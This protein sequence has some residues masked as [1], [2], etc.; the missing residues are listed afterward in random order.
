LVLDEQPK[1]HTVASLYWKLSK[2]GH[3]ET[4]PMEHAMVADLPVAGP[5]LF[6]SPEK[7]RTSQPASQP[8]SLGGMTAVIPALNFFLSS[9]HHP[10]MAKPTQTLS[11]FIAQPQTTLNPPGE[12]YAFIPHAES[13]N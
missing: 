5:S 9:H 7:L 2:Q 8:V 10:W 11:S 1:N 3:I 12:L 4:S 6:A 13:T